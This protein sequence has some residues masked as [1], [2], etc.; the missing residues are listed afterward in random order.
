MIIDL[1]SHLIP[2]VDDGA[3]S[4]EDS[5]TIARQGVED[6]VSHVVLTPHHRNGQFVNHKKD[7]LEETKKLQAIYDQAGVNLKVYPGQ[8]IRITENLLDDLYNDNLLSLDAGGK[9]YLIE[10][11]TAKVPEFAFSLILELINQGITPIIAHPERNHGF[12]KD[13]HLLYK[14]IEAGCLSQITSS[15]YVNLYGEKFQ[16]IAKDMIGLDL[17]HI[18]ASDVHNTDFRPYNLTQAYQQLEADFGSEKVQYFKDNARNILN[19]DPVIKRPPQQVKASK[20]K[21]GFNFFG[22]FGKK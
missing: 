2:S 5:L 15:S 4:I 20:K 9:Y 6:G 7:V 21:K 1:H 18:L 17:A 13:Y 22:L 11:P 10:F 12:A 14:F 16:G 3:K 8:E 19:G